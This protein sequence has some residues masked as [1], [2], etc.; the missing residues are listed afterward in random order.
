MIKKLL[1]TVLGLLLVAGALVGTKV[2]QFRAMVEAGANMVPPPEVVTA[3]IVRADEWE[4]TLLPVGTL[5]A[6]QG[7]TVRAEVQ[8]RIVRIAFE[9]G[10]AVATGAVLVEFDVSTETAELRAAEAAA[11]LAKADL[12][13]TRD[14]F[15]NKTTSRA[16]LDAAEAG[17]EEAE[18]E[19]DSIRAAIA[20]KTVRAP[21][22]GR[23]GLRQ[24][25]L[26]EVLAEGDAIASL[27]TLDPIY[28]DFSLPQQWLGAVAPGTSVRVTTDAA[29]GE[30]YA[31]NVMAVSPVVDTVTRTV[32]VRATIANHAEK[33]RAGMFANVEVVLP[34]RERVLA[35][36]LT[37]VHFAPYGDSVFV[38]EEQP[39][40]G[41]AA[42]AQVLTQR[43]VRL[44][45]Q[46]GDFV[47]VT[48]GLEAGDQVVSSGV[49]KLRSGMKVVIDN[50]L[51][52]QAEL[53][54][55]PDN[56]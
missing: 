12:A 31:G 37:A 40:E 39:G 53:A 47:A 42:P 29:P 51:A 35:I 54:P 44:G 25:N 11:V 21:F 43:F 34:T 36:P 17:F 24:V 2:Q 23:L 3:A 9:S 1:L 22:S 50:T 5:V 56:S 16:A 45:T 49:F 15:A 10:D 41:G 4:H 27:Q 20:K 26:G 14:L 52:P 32:R 7:V 30:V 6:V 55:R 18:A 28:A 13:R 46:R 19:V 33:L 38:I 8:G 48:E